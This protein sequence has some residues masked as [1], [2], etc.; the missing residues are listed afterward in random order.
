MLEIRKE[1]ERGM[2]EARAIQR[3]I[4]KKGRMMQIE[5]ERVKEKKRKI[6]RES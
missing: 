5:C 6:S 1:G 4:E 2:V 3:E